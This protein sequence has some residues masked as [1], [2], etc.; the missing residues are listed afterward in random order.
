M[1]KY[2]PCESRRPH[3][4]ILAVA[5][6]LI[7]FSLLGIGA[8]TG[9]IPSAYSKSVGEAQANQPVDEKALSGKAPAQKLAVRTSCGNCGVVDSVR[10]VQLEGGAS[11]VGAVAGGLTGA[12]VGNQIGNGRGRDAMTLLGGVGGAFAGHSIEKSINRHTA[13]RV[14]VRMDD[15]SYRTISQSHA[16]AIPVGSKVRLSNGSLVE[17]S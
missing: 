8:I 12:V 11:G 4:V 7:I 15:G 5:A 16:P 3:P 9:L 2:S 14:T 10:A 6:S 13:Y 1:K 17:L